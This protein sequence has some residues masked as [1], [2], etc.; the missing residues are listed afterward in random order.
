MQII[1]QLMKQYQLAFQQL[2]TSPAFPGD[3]FKET[4]VC[5]GF[6]QFLYILLKYSYLVSFGSVKMVFILQWSRISPEIH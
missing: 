3:A 4:A 2:G 5:L 1:I 6:L